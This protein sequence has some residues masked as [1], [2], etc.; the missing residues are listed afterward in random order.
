MRSFLC[1]LSVHCW[2]VAA[3]ERAAASLG[4]QVTAEASWVRPTDVNDQILGFHG[5][6]TPWASAIY[7]LAKLIL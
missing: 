4:A 6:P 7:P 2:L 3:V 1:L 5:G